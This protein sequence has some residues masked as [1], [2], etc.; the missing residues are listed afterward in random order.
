VSG[1]ELYA[2]GIITELRWHQP[3]Q[4]PVIRPYRQQPPQSSQ[5][6]QKTLFD[7]GVGTD[8]LPESQPNPQRI[9]PRPQGGTVSGSDPSLVP[10]VLYA[11]NLPTNQ[12]PAHQRT[13]PRDLPD[14][15]LA[16]WEALPREDK[17]LAGE[18][19]P[20]E[21]QPGPRPEP[22]QWLAD[23]AD[24]EPLLSAAKAL[25]PELDWGERE[26]PTAAA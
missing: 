14:Q 16:D 17:A 2:S 7:I 11:W 3:A 9:P 18:P 22:T 8:W 6:L 25:H 13:R 21:G 4:V 1:F 15:L 20:A 19:F 10:I 12:P 23:R 5:L 26:E 24:P